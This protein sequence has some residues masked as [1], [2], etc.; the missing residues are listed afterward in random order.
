MMKKILSTL[1]KLAISGGILYFL[2]SSMDLAAFWETVKSVSPFAVIFVAL[3]FIFIQSV[4][5]YRWSLILSKDIEVRYPK[6]LSIYFVGMFFNNFLPTM[7]GGDLVKALYLY[8][9]TGKGGLS[10]ASIFMDRYSGFSALM[11]I[12]AVALIPG[13]SLIKGT[14]LPGVFVFII[15]GF[16]G[17]SLVVWVGFLHSWAMNIL[18]KIHFY[19][20]NKKIDSFYRVLMGYKNHRDI[21]VKIFSISLVVQTGVI[22]SCYVLSRGLGI[23]VGLAYFFLFIPLSIVVSMLPISVAGLGI[24][25]GAFV[26]LFTKVGA[27]KEEAITLSLMWFAM[28][29]IVSLIGGVEFLRTGGKKGGI[30]ET[31]LEVE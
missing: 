28:M 25:E 14:V 19:G 6:L 26:Y 24:R 20:I 13:Y 16:V 12:T 8:R 10:L 18:A 30:T 11:S 1:I 29:V 17:A 27:T 21:L 9:E 23:D 7:V 5:A 4:S 22:I 15:G 2:F 3:F 31:P